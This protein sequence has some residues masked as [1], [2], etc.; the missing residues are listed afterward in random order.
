MNILVKYMHGGNMMILIDRCQDRGC[1]SPSPYIPNN[2][3]GGVGLPC[4]YVQC[5]DFILCAIYRLAQE[6]VE[7]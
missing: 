6:N 4:L 1:F 5:D 7:C 3:G 2:G